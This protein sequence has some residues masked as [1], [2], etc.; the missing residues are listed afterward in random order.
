MRGD[1]QIQVIQQQQPTM[2]MQ[3][4]AQPQAAPDQ[5]LSQL[6]AQDPPDAQSVSVSSLSCTECQDT[7]M[8]LS[9]AHC[10]TLAAID[11][12]ACTGCEGLPRAEMISLAEQAQDNRG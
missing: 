11:E 2:A 3:L 6:T 12:H 10:V 4:V 5:E 1:P 9:R 8:V 7:G